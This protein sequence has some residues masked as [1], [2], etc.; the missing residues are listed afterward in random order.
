[1]HLKL[2]Y[3]SHNLLV[4]VVPWLSCGWLFVTQRVFSRLPCPLSPGV[5]S[6]LYPLSQW[7]HSIISSS[8]APFSSCPQS[9]LASGSFKMSWFFASNGQS[10][11]CLASA[12]VLPMNYSGLISFAVDWFDH[13][14]VQ[15][16]RKSL[17]SRTTVWKHQFFSTQPSL[18]SS[19]HLHTWLLEKP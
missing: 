12:S 15:G 19:C 3:C 13:L 8:V 11:G 5:C 9:F 7:C 16:T 17:L 1:M 4:L 18:W 10:S 2:E 14:A 6:N